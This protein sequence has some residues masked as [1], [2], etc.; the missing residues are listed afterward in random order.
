MLNKSVTFR[1][2][3]LWL[4]CLNRLADEADRNQ[5]DFLRDLVWLLTIDETVTQ[6]VKA[7]MKALQTSY[8]D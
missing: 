4:A 2:D 1:V 8:N 7:S 6:A 3:G 5:S